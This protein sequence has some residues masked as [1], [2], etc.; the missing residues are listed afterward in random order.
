MWP[1]ESGHFFALV[2]FCS[3]VASCIQHSCDPMYCSPPGY[4][5]HGISQA[6]IPEWVAK[7]SPGNLCDPGI[8]LASP[9]CHTPSLPLSAWEALLSVSED[10]LLPSVS[11][12]S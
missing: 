1:R 7:D 10:L 5:V 11:I 8:E 4:S 9:V 2:V 12:L 6:R 3:L